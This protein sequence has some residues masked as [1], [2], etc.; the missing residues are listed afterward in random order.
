MSQTAVLHVSHY[1]VAFQVNFYKNLT[2]LNLYYLRNV[3]NYIYSGGFLCLYQSITVWNLTKNTHLYISDLF[4]LIG[5]DRKILNRWKET[6][7]NA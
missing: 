5:R 7:P 1:R 2:G 6:L 3:F 4:P